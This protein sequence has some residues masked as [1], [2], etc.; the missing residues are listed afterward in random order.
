[1]ID[2]GNPKGNYY[3]VDGPGGTGK[4]TLFNALLSYVRSKLLMGNEGRHHIAVAVAA[5]GIASLLLRGGRTAHN[6]FGLGAEVNRNSTC[7]YNKERNCARTQILR[8]AEIII[9]DEATMNSKHLMHAV[10][11]C[12]RDIMDN[13]KPFGGKLVVFGGDFRQTLSVV[14]GGNRA[15]EVEACI[16]S[17]PLWKGIITRRLKVN[18]R[19]LINENEENKAKLKHWSEFLLR[20]GEGREKA[21]LPAAANGKFYSKDLIEI[22]HP[23]VSQARSPQELISEIYPDLERPLDLDNL[24]DSAILT[25]MNKDVDLLNQLAMNRVRDDEKTLWSNDS[26]VD[27]GDNSSGF[28]SEEFLNGIHL[29]GLPDHKLT[30]KKGVPVMILRNLAPTKGVC[31]G[32]RMI[33]DKIGKYV[34]VARIATGLRKS[35]IFYIPRIVCSTTTKK[36]SFQLLRRQFPV[37][38]A[39]AMSINKS[40]G[41]TLKNVGLFLPRAVFSHGQLYVAL[42]R[43]GDPDFIKVLV[44]D[45]KEQG[46][47]HHRVFT[48]NVVYKEVLV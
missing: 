42:S 38:V 43:V 7:R 44:L 11:L 30:L 27:N 35:E 39:Y 34:L 48:R 5:S 23:I 12:L 25:P 22:P 8:R 47:V 2:T 24:E 13:D 46:T 19:V 26:V 18:M 28:Y 4:T 32:T 14:E 9:W 40:Q 21:H 41:Q 33:I 6:R 17:S 45:T 20:V 1:M 10:D 15:H 3:F 31:N 16:K 36:Y 37:R 29:A